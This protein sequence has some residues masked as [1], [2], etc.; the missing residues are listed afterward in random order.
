MKY[1]ICRFLV[2]KK[3]QLCFLTILYIK[4][5]NKCLGERY[6]ERRA[7]ALLIYRDI[8]Y[9]LTFQYWLLNWAFRKLLSSC[10]YR[11]CC[12]VLNLF[13]FGVFFWSSF[14]FFYSFFFIWYR[15]IIYTA[16]GVDNK[17]YKLIWAFVYT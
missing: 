5:K 14:F 13:L 11:C 12:V 7:P 8:P 3:I 6:Y 15:F 1:N 16:Y 4:K 2:S 9:S 17:I 10:C